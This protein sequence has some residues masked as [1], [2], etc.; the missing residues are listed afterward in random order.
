M[1]TEGC[2]GEGVIRGLWLGERWWKNS[3]RELSLIG[4]FVID[5]KLRHTVVSKRKEKRWGEKGA[6]CCL[7]IAPC[8]FIG[9]IYGACNSFLFWI[10]NPGFERFHIPWFVCL[11]AVCA[12]GRI[13]CRHNRCLQLEPY[14]IQHSWVKDSVP[15]STYNHFWLY[16][17]C[18][19]YI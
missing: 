19:S 13:S 14:T 11:R 2:D 5:A 6:L 12:C 10:Q 18:R 3:I 9:H 4:S 7:D 17:F 15:H 1:T 8:A 16:T